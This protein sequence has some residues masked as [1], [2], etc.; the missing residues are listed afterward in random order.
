MQHVERYLPGNYTVGRGGAKVEHLVIHTIEGS[1]ASA[2][3][4]FRNPDRNASTHDGVKT[5]EVWLWVRMKDTAWG[6]GDSAINKA[7][8]NIET[9]GYAR[10][11]N[12]PAALLDSIAER[13]AEVLVHTADN[14]AIP[15]LWT[16]ERRPGVKGHGDITP[17]RRWD[18]GAM[19]VGYLTWRLGRLGVA[20]DWDKGVVLKATSPISNRESWMVH[21]V[22]FVVGATVDGL[23]G[24]G[25]ASLV[26]QYQA[27]IGVTADGLWGHGTWTRHMQI[28]RAALDK[29]YPLPP[30]TPPPTPEPLPD[31]HDDIW[32]AIKD[33]QAKVAAQAKE[34]SAAHDKI[35]NLQANKAGVQ[36]PHTIT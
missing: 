8:H 4:V 14:Y 3:A 6:A 30:P 15:K 23:Y 28:V 9:E 22:Q 24:N 12:R 29:R 20:M 27:K 2:D 35:R 5:G 17:D 19:D 7:G 16:V 26:K 31:T 18:P 10:D 21:Y 25:T 34:I 33:L 11:V 13:M 32:A 1:V 36:H